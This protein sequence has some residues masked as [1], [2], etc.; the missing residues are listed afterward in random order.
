MEE[1]EEA[2]R[3]G[4]PLFFCSLLRA[5]SLPEER[6]KKK[7]KKLFKRKKSLS[8]KFFLFSHLDV[9]EDDPLRVALR[10]EPQDGPSDVRDPGLGEGAPAGRLQHGAAGA[11]LLF[12]SF[13]YFFE[14]FFFLSSP[15]SL[16]GKKSPLFPL[17]L[18][19]FP[20]L[21]NQLLP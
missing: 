4:W 1:E 9:P 10:Q 11:E 12:L 14:S 19:L 21:Q 2:E 18:F 3:G 15:F 17:F 6:R 7:Q 16:V 5:L 13:F 20:P 8:P